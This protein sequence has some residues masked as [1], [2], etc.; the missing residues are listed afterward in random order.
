MICI[1]EKTNAILIGRHTLTETSLIVHWCAPECGLF[2]TVAK[3]A[4]R[5]K[6]AFAGRLDLFVSAEIR[7]TRS[8]KSDLHTLSEAEWTEPRLALRT[9]YLR[10]LAATYLVRL[11]ELM[12]ERETPLLAIHELLEKALDYLNTHEPSKRLIERFELRLAEELGVSSPT[13]KPAVALQMAVHHALPAQR[14]QLW[15]RLEAVGGSEA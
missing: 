7:F 8:H 14:R 12:V 6:S 3:G 11:V 1:V 9:S 13:S 15:Q 5:P 4:L 2:K 10:V